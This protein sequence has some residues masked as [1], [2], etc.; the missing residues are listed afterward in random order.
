MSGATIYDV[1]KAA[2]VSHQ[3]V[4]RYLRGSA[5][6]RPETGERVQSALDALGYKLNSAARYLRTQRVNRLGVLAHHLDLSGP[7]RLLNGVTG[8]ARERGY[9]LDIVAV[10]GNDH[11]DVERGLDLVL[12]QQVAGIVIVAQSSIVVRAVAARAA[13]L[14]MSSDV[15]VEGET[16]LNAV[17]G[18]VAA[19]HLADLGHTRLA[20][21]AGPATWPSARDRREGFLQEARRRGCAVV[22]E[23]EG[24]WSGSSAYAIARSLPVEELGISAV[25]VANDSMA[26]AIIAALSDRG[27]RVPEDVSVIGTDDSPESR[28]L[29]P[30]LTT[31]DV[32]QEDEGAHMLISL[33]A[34]IEQSDPSVVPAIRS[35]A[36]VPRGSTA[37]T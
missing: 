28:Y 11:V 17:A 25:G 2:G 9:L 21:I 13:D 19:S 24:D 31:V 29:R 14:P 12:G 8:A 4:S 20:Y 36:L 27:L 3:T 16:P 18:S 32:H 7:V 1:A 10:D 34:M 5:Q 6:V 33:V 23:A 22:W 15:T 35:P 37:S 26:V 30:A